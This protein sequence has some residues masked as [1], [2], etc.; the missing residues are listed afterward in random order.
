MVKITKIKLFFIS[1]LPGLFLIGLNIGTG[2]VTA[3]AKAGAHYGMSLLWTIAISSFITYFLINTYGKFTIITKETALYS[4]KKNIHSVV[5]M[6]FIVALTIN[7]C[8]SVMGVMGIIADVCYVWSLNY[9]ENGIHPIFFAAFFV[10]FVYLLFLIGKTSSIEKSMAIIVGIM[11]LSFILNFFILMPS[12]E[13]ILHGVIPKIPK[14]VVNSGDSP[15]LVVAS[16]VGTTVF[17]GLFIIRTIL[18]RESGW[19]IKNLN[20][21]RRDAIISAL[22]MFIISA[23]IM[24]SAAGMLFGAGTGLNTA[25]QMMNLLQPLA[26][27]FASTIFGVGIIAAGI[28]S[29]FP[30]VIML[31]MLLSDYNNTPLNLRK[32]HIKLI[33]LGISLLGLVVPIFNAPP[34]LVMIA[35]QAFGALLLPFTVACMLYL[36]NKKELMK[37]YAFST[38]VNI[39]MIV[40]GLFSLFIAYNSL[41]GIIELFL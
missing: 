34:V 17:S 1:I 6:F 31:P 3:M 19:T 22:M 15:Y 40:I 8:G 11:S 28:S 18:V 20:I 16:M 39:I 4:F 27:S 14:E 7:V 30:N 13:T 38:Q 5:G 36:G 9:T 12:L 29:Q 2:S 23:S 10:V 25:S 33:V 32:K 35:S 26:G 24:A 41:K 21:Q 37:S